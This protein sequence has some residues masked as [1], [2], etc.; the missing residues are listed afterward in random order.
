[1]QSGVLEPGL[2]TGGPETVRCL[3]PASGTGESCSSFLE[4]PGLWK[5]ATTAG[6]MMGGETS[7]PSAKLLRDGLRVV[8]S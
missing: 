4:F 8:F 7:G 1:M 3:T 6:G 2:E 5:P